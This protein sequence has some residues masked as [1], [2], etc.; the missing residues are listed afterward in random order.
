MHARQRNPSSISSLDPPAAVA[1]AAALLLPAI[2]NGFPLIFPDSGTYLQIAL[3]SAY[4]IDRSSIYGFFLKPLVGS[5]P[6]VAGLWIAICVQALLVGAVLW[7]AARLLAKDLP[8]AAIIA[9]LTVLLTSVSLHAG[10]FMPDAFTGPT[11]LLGWMAARRDPTASGSPLLWLAAGA[12]ALMHYTHLPLLLAAAFAAI[13]AQMLVGL[14]WG[15]G[16][17]RAVAAVLIA[18]S[19]AGI[20]LGLNSVALN[21]TSIAP[22]GPLFLFARLHEDGII[23]PWLAR[24][25]GDDAPPKLCVIAPQLPRSSQVLLWGGP[26]TPITTLVWHPADEATRWE[27]IDAMAVA[28]R[29]AIAQ[30][31]G[32]FLANSLAGGVRQFGAFAAFDDECPRGCHDRVGGIGY[33]LQREMPVALPALDASRQVT[34]TM[35]KAPVRFVT[36]L[37]AI[38][39]LLMLPFAAWMCWRRREADLLTLIAAVAACLAVNALL[40]GALS[41]V[42]ERYQSRIVWLAPFAILAFAVR[43]WR[44]GA[45]PEASERVEQRSGNGGWWSRGGSNP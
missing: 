21:R 9:G 10:Q 8:G 4:A 13:G 22:A 7:A 30:S 32:K 27:T 23:Q 1:T 11:I 19:V 43:R 45:V 17:R 5:A 20:Q 25:C 12:A 38:A 36:S 31:P 35:P 34:D 15:D 29:G 44:R 3:S 18:A 16:L 24:H 40:A 28:N 41:D 42:H 33:T 37:V 6:G 14:R 39:A 26:K 2:Y